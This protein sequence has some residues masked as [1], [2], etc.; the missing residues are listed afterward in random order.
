MPGMVV[1]IAGC[2]STNRS[3]SSGIYLHACRQQRTQTVDAFDDGRQL[4]PLEVAP[5]EIALTYEFFTLQPLDLALPVAVVRPGVVPDVKLLKVD[6][7]DA[8]I[9]QAPL[10]VLAHVVGRIRFA[11]GERGCR[12]VFQFFGGI[13]VA[14]KTGV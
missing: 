8:E 10:G 11:D 14:T 13:L 5:P 12:R 2:S 9:P 7:V 6:R 3:A 1:L 4:V